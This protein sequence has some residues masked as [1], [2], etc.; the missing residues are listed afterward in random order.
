MAL[1]HI[2]EPGAKVRLGDFD[3]SD[4]K[5]LDKDSAKERVETLGKEIGE[6]QELLFAARD[7]ALLLV[8][9]GP[10]TAGKDGAINRILSYVNVQSAQV[11]G[12]KVPTPEELAHDFLWRVHQKAPGKGGVTVFNRSH[13]EDVLVVRVHSI[14]P[15]PVWSARYDQINEF[16]ELL[17]ENGTIIL[18]FFLHIDQDEQEERLLAREENPVKSWKLSVNDW[19]EREHWDAYVEAYE[20]A[21]A[22]C[23]PKHAPWH[24]VP[25]NK[26]WFRDAAIAEALHAALAPRREGW[27]KKLDEMGV[28]AKA[29]LAEF[30]QG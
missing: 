16:E 14:V 29:E 24:I 13:Y 17:A 19:K 22:R 6:L 9:Q 30:R 15:K 27:M 28:K 11:A 1:T 10:D 5:G 2:V 12:F 25:A 20:E 21:F 8:F 4:T 18:K 26:K 7:T 23:S 3:P